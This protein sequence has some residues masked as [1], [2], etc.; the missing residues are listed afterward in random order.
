MA[1][2]KH[3][4]VFTPSTGS[5]DIYVWQEGDGAA[6]W[7]VAFQYKTDSRGGYWQVFLE[8][9]DKSDETTIF[10]FATLAEAV[11]C[12]QESRL[13]FDL[14]AQMVAEVR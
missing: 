12:F 10:T 11:Q 13:A 14:P 7:Q 8:K 5:I 9:L 4:T 1:T 6:E 3:Q 2:T